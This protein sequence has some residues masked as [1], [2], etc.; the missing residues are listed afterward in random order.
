MKK[1][2]TSWTPLNVVLPNQHAV[3]A[4]GISPYLLKG[5]DDSIEPEEPVFESFIKPP[6]EPEVIFQGHTA[7]E[8]EQARQDAHKAGYE[9]GIKEGNE[10]G[11]GEKY[12][13][14]QSISASFAA[15]GSQIESLVTAYQQHLETSRKE[16]TRLAFEVAEKIAGEALEENAFNNIAQL[17]EQSLGFILHEPK[18]TLHVHP[19]LQARV[20]QHLQQY[21]PNDDIREHITIQTQDSMEQ[22]DCR[23]EWE[24]GGAELSVA[25]RWQHIRSLLQEDI[26]ELSDA[27]GISAK[28]STN[29]D[30]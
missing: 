22:T 8:L 10:A 4:D 11:K 25:E 17:I 9:Q 23:I 15:A 27:E 18:I 19:E 2:S 24:Q 14:D 3:I 30:T 6:P 29:P 28:T 13:L 12:Q 5:D 1:W 16:L 7:E 20:E 26:A 21:I